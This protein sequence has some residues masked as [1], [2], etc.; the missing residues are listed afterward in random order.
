M[1]LALPL[2]LIRHCGSHFRRRIASAVLVG[3]LASQA[4][5]SAATSDTAPRL[6][7]QVKAGYLFNFLRFTE[8]PPQALPAGA[9]YRIGVVEDPGTYNIIAESLR[10]KTVN[11]HAIEVVYLN[12]R[13]AV[14]GCHLVFVPRSVEATSLNLGSATDRENTLLVGETAGYAVRDGMIGFVQRGH[15]IR[16]QVNLQA[17]QHAGLKLSGRLASLAE[18]VQ[19]P[20][21]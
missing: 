21:Q 1:L 13:D 15:N 11:N 16:F 10:G 2:F 9:P 5:V 19:S 18:I 12:S 20:P 7:Y 17:A 4:S 8:W 6:E 14:R 3:V